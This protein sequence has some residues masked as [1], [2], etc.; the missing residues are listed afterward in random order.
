[1]VLRPS[2]TTP[3]YTSRYLPTF[4]GKRLLYSSAVTTS[5]G[6]AIFGFSQ[7]IISSIQIQ[8]SFFK[9]IF[10]LDVS[11]S[12]IQS[13]H[14][15]VNPWV[16][17]AVVS[18]LNLTALVS[19]LVAPCI[20][21]SLG[22]R[23]AIH[24]GG[25]FVVVAFVVQGA[26]P[27]IIALAVGRCIQGLAVG[28]LSTTVPV[29]QCEIAPD[30]SRGLFVSIEYFCLSFGSVLSTW[31]AYGFYFTEGELSWCGPYIIQG[32][33][34]L[35]LVNFTWYLPETPHW[36]IHHGRNEDALQTLTDLHANGYT[37]NQSVI[38]Q[39]EFIRASIEPQAGQLTPWMN[40]FYEFPLR[41]M[42]E[43]S[44]QLFAQFNGYSAISYILPV[45]LLQTGTTIPQTLIL[46][47]FSGLLY[48]SGT[49]IPLLFVDK[50]G[51]KSFL[52]V[53]RLALAAVLCVVGALQIN[54]D[55]YGTGFWGKRAICFYFIVFG[56]TWGPISWLLGAEMFPIVR[57]HL[58]FLSGPSL[59]AF[60]GSCA[61]G[62]GALHA[63]TLV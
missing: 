59:I 46:C 28:I 11:V 9:R 17:S 3:S 7:G 29:Y 22:R 5:L 63:L 37:D 13:G 40:L 54:I 34:S 38:K 60:Q 18:C 52:L 43:I 42:I 39:Y 61:K 35:V 51:R 27:N 26:A 24:V 10:N 23:G 32:I 53:G 14:T 31:V 57:R 6:D 45:L 15:S 20:C 4:A 2:S 8:P 33:L 44:S 48:C 19:S 21:D 56:A 12:Q 25:V 47:R 49:I 50:R 58:S 55:Y 36:L 1:M 16:V 62:A 30:K 41:T